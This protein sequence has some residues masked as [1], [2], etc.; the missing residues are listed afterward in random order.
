MSTRLEEMLEF[1]QIAEETFRKPP[2]RREAPVC[3]SVCL[4]VCLS[5]CLYVCLYVCLSVCLSACPH[6]CLPA[7]MHFLSVCVCLS[8]SL[9]LCLPGCPSAGLSGCLSVCLPTLFLAC[10]LFYL[11][12]HLSILP[13]VCLAC[14]TDTLG[15]QCFGGLDN[16]RAAGFVAPA[17]S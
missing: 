2:Q 4:F 11:D 8:L 6:A 14:L 10:L 12:P 9:S 1:R 16:L 17:A 3:L 7:C 13:S 15:M 5:V